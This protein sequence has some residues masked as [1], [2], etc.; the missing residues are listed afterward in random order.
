[1][2]DGAGCSGD[3]AGAFSCGAPDCALSGAGRDSNPNTITQHKTR[4]WWIRFIGRQFYQSPQ[5]E[6]DIC[7]NFIFHSFPCFTHTVLKC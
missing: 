5:C 1:M 7:R 6:A 2:E 3:F 4:V